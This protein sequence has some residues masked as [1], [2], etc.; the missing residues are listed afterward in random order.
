MAEEKNTVE[1]ENDAQALPKPVQPKP[2]SQ[3]KPAKKPRKNASANAARREAE[4]QRRAAGS[5]K[6]KQSSAGAAPQMKILCRAGQLLRRHTMH[7]QGQR[8]KP[9]L[10]KRPQRRMHR[11]R[12]PLPR[13][14]NGKSCIHS[15]LYRSRLPVNSR[16]R[17]LQCR[18]ARPQSRTGPQH[19][20][21]CPKAGRPLQKML[22][23][24]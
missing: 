21:L 15:P 20:R 5:E 22:L 9:A 14:K 11:L 1:K 16:S 2:A 12:G 23:M 24:N 19:R 18:R 6:K 8:A 13:K 4:K 17:H 10:F 3:K 7:L